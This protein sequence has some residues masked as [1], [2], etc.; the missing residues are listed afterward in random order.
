MFIGAYLFELLATQ[1][2]GLSLS[3]INDLKTIPAAMADNIK[4]IN[5]SA[6]IVTLIIP[7]FLFAYLAY[8]SP[9]TY[10]G[11]TNNVKGAHLALAFVLILVAIPFTGLLEQWSKLIPAMGNSKEADE[12]Y[13]RLAEAMLQGTTS[14]DLFS[15]IFFISIAP[16][17]IEEI[18]FRG[19]L[20]QILLNWMRKTPFAAIFLVAALFSLFHWQLSGFFPR[21]FLGLLLGL[22][23]YY[24]GSLWVSI[25]MHAINNFV[26]V[27]LIFLFNTKTIAMDITQLPNVN[28]WVGA[29]S[30]IAV[31][32]IV[33]LFYKDRKECTLWEV[34][35]EPPIF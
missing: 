12:Q 8:P 27:L 31:C 16:A 19:C 21:L 2:T 17:L 6:L 24:S 28:M 14:K 29:G 18:F 34:E 23:Y 4:I 30:G 33:Y 22:A 26:S 15:N 32:G 9:T 10:L 3:E 1:L 7:A 5:T 11:L 35:R 13:N 20:Q 25:L